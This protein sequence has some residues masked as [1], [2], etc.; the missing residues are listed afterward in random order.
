MMAI[1]FFTMLFILFGTIVLV[2]EWVLLALLGVEKCPPEVFLSLRQ[3]G[4]KLSYIFNIFNKLT[5]KS[6]LAQT[7]HFDKTGFTDS[8][9][10]PQQA[11]DCINLI[12]ESQDASIKNQGSYAS[13]QNPIYSGETFEKQFVLCGGQL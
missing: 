8:I 11:R 1:I 5:V 12:Y 6:H 4:G 3:I 2:L 10:H 7:F 9:Y 13:V